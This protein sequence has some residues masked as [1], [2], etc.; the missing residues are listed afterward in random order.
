MNQVVRLVMTKDRTAGITE[1]VLFPLSEDEIAS[2]FHVHTMDQL[3][4]A[5]GLVPYLTVSEFNT[6][7]READERAEKIT[8]TI[9]ATIRF[10]KEKKRNSVSHHAVYEIIWLGFEDAA[11]WELC[12]QG[13]YDT[14][15]GVEFSF[16]G[17]LLQVLY[18]G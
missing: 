17:M 4:F 14:P 8:S 1:R 15:D 18:R 7:M 9:E 2:R 11:V 13:S 6:A 12:M 3:R 10:L 5:D 16:S